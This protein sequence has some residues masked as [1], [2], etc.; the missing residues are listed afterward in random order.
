MSGVI[1][2]IPLIGTTG[3]GGSAGVAT[4]KAARAVNGLLYGVI[5][6]KGDLEDGVDLTLS[7]VNS[8]T[9]VTLLTLTDANTDQ[10]QFYP[11]GNSCGATGASNADGL[12]MLPVVGV[13]QLAVAQGGTTKTGGVYALV[14][15]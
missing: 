1:S 14:M 13:L 11:R 2:V 15:E 3:S 12:I 10:A 5:E 8:E 6:D 4:I 9:A 7:V